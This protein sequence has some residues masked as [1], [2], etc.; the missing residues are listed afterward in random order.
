MQQLP[1]AH[2]LGTVQ[3]CLFLTHH[4]KCDYKFPLSYNQINM[5][6]VCVCER[7]N[8]SFLLQVA[9]IQGNWCRGLSDN[10]AIGRH[11]GI[12]YIL[13]LLGLFCCCC[14]TFHSLGLVTCSDS[15]FSAFTEQHNTEKRRHTSMP[16]VGLELT[17]PVFKCFKTV[18]AL[19]RTATGT[20]CFCSCSW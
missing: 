2:L 19:D 7:E 8:S 15:E 1:D 10:P 18:R 12:I 16:R 4:F 6:C 9:Q 13:S 11:N 20:G 14:S 17:N 3:S 5:V